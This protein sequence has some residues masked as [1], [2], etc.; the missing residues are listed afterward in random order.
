M[1]QKDLR[2]YSSANFNEKMAAGGIMYC[3]AYRKCLH[4]KIDRIQCT[5]LRL[6]VH[7]SLDSLFKL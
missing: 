7:R 6:L 1:V 5:L 2:V 3:F 4:D